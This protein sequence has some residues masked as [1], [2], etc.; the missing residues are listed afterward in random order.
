MFENACAI[1]AIS[2][3]SKSS[4]LG[5]TDQ[6]EPLQNTIQLYPFVRFQKLHCRWWANRELLIRWC[7]VF[8]SGAKTAQDKDWFGFVINSHTIT[9]SAAPQHMRKFDMFE[10]EISFSL[11]THLLFGSSKPEAGPRLAGMTDKVDVIW[12][13]HGLGTQGSAGHGNSLPCAKKDGSMQARAWPCNCRF[14]TF[15]M[16]LLILPMAV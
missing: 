15:F 10:T 8:P 1:S 2:A 3:I 6:V 13:N 14:I 11:H 12:S 4:C 9:V 16:H 5:C 7:L